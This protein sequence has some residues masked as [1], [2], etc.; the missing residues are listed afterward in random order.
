[1]S[2]DAAEALRW[3]DRAHRLAPDDGTATLALATACLRQDNARA[4][5]LFHAITEAGEVREAWLGL[6]VA[7]LGAGDT[8]GAAAALAATLA[9]HAPDDA[10]LAAGDKPGG[11]T[12]DALADTP[13]EDRKSVG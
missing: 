11:S 1:M 3:L 10:L 4:E 13:A 12:G 2:G 5:A 7:R 8:A 9:R 6:A